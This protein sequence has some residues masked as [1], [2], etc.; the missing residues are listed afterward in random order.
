M[1]RQAKARERK[2][3][4]ELRRLAQII[5][6]AKAEVAAIRSDEV[7]GRFVNT[8]TDELD[9]IVAATAEA[10]NAIMD[11]TEGI[12]KVMG[13]LQ[14]DAATGLMDATTKIYEACGF[15]DITGQRISK[16]VKAIK[17][18]EARIDALNAAF[19]ADVPPGGRAGGKEAAPAPKPGGDGGPKP[20]TDADLLNGP[21]LRTKAK[22]QE[23]IDAMLTGSGR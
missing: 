15:Q 8:A 1:D 7:K 12:E 3:R 18:I 14:G 9:A 22:T 17:E 20:I 16:V 4:D 2:V 19:E 11:A 6:T 10:T 21:Q 13:A 23:E 5:R